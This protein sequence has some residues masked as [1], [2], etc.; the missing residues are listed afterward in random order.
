MNMPEI[1]NPFPSPR[2]HASFREHRVAGRDSTQALLDAIP[3]REDMLQLLQ[4]HH[5]ISVRHIDREFFAQIFRLAARFELG[6]LEHLRPCIGKVLTSAFLDTPDHP[7]RFS[8]A[9]AWSRLGGTL[10]NLGKTFT[11]LESQPCALFELAEMSNNYGQIAVLRTLQA[12]T[13]HALLPQFRIPVVN[14]GNGYDENPTHGITDLYTIFKMRPDL[15]YTEVPEERRLNVAVAGWP[16]RSRTI[17]SFLLGLSK[18]SN[19]INKVIIFE[20][21]AT[22]FS[23]GQ[24]EELEQAGLNLVI[25]MELNPKDTMLD[26]V[27]KVLPQIDVVLIDASH[28]QTSR[29]GAIQELAAVKPGALLLHPNLLKEEYRDFFYDNENNGYFAQTRG[30]I[31][32]RMALLSSICG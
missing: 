32:V 6:E 9:S 2:A 10:I 24:R 21:M 26:C 17:R 18:F 7:T 16:A 12:Q 29:Q 8:F 28:H 20:R 14:A 11:G 25:G 13:L 19:V 27:R 4:G 15:L 5:L 31:A 22:M 3:N 1:V 23:D 30:G